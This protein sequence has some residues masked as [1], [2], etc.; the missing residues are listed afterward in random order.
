MDKPT[1]S[2]NVDEAEK[3][4]R[5][6]LGEEGSRGSSSPEFNGGATLPTPTVSWDELASTIAEAES[7]QNVWT[8]KPVVGHNQGFVKNLASVVGKVFLYFAQVVTKPQQAFNT[9]VMR[10]IRRITEGLQATQENIQQVQLRSDKLQAIE[11]DLAELRKN[12]DERIETSTKTVERRMEE[13]HLRFNAIPILEKQ[14]ASLESRLDILPQLERSIADTKAPLES[15]PKIEQSLVELTRRHDVLE[16]SIADTKAQLE[17]VP[18]IE[19]SLVELTRRNDLLERSIADTRAQL[20]SISKIEHSLVELTRRIDVLERANSD[21]KAQLESVPKIEH[22]LVELTNRTNLLPGLERRI[23]DL[24]RAKE[25]LLVFLTDLK[26]TVSELQPQVVHVQEH[27]A[28]LMTTM[29][30]YERRIAVILEEARSR[31]PYPFDQDQLAVLSHELDVMDEELYLEFENKYRGSRQE[32][33]ERVKAYIPIIQKAGAGSRLQPVLDVGCGRGEWLEV[34]KDEGLIGF[35][36]DSS[37]TMVEQ[38]KVL[39]LNVEQGD[40]LE[41]LKQIQ[42]ESLGAVTGFHIIEHLP[43]KVWIK[44]FDEAFRIL[45]P[46]GVMIFE[47]PNPENVFVSVNTFY[48]DPSHIRP[49]PSELVRFVGEARGFCNVEIL[50]LHPMEGKN[51]IQDNSEIANRFNRYFYGPR[52]YAIIAWKA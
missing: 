33:K 21:T 7:H 2:S 11:S 6:K 51:L 29:I 17:S 9:S 18:K 36:L 27:L 43:F 3:R 46:G 34:L 13:L 44:V 23:E 4:L 12:L 14:L 47:T 31:M 24:N 8:T 32:V 35:G 25:S 39:G 16:R 50:N 38:C 5:S 40:V 20:E 1:Q 15:V 26:N 41:Y 22:S 52:D 28:R 19:Q 45:K 49:L 48:W 42:D 37:S 10:S 30:G